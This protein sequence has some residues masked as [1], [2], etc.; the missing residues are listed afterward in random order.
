[1]EFWTTT[2]TVLSIVS[3]WSSG[4]LVGLAMMGTVMTNQRQEEERVCHSHN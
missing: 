1:M 4:F 3:L 2:E